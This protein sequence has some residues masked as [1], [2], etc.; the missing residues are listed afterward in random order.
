MRIQCQSCPAGSLGGEIC[1]VLAL[2]C[3]PGPLTGCAG[4]SGVQPGNQPFTLSTYSKWG[5][6]LGQRGGLV[7]G[8]CRAA[9][10]T[11]FRA[12][13]HTPHTHTRTR[14]LTLT[15]RHITH[16]YTLSRAHTHVHTCSQDM[17]LRPGTRGATQGAGGGDRGWSHF[18]AVGCGPERAGSSKVTQPVR[19]GQG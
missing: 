10:L 5:G 14:T 18:T 4:H 3:L 8:G 16:A 6:W 17:G 2:S 13:R 11:H 12:R 7:W 1:W 15:P 9:V 19:L